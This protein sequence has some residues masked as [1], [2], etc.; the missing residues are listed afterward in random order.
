MIVYRLIRQDYNL[1]YCSAIKSTITEYEQIGELYDLLY[2]MTIYFYLLDPLNS[3]PPYGQIYEEMQVLYR[4]Y[5]ETR[6][7]RF[8]PS[9]DAYY[10][11][12]KD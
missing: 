3:M 2:K 6:T 1:E 4:K 5:L 7:Q 12:F 11:R 9:D 10:K 8:I